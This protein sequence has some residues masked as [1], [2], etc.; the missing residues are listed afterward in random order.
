MVLL[1][2]QMFDCS[3][4][5]SGQQLTSNDSFLQ[6]GAADALKH[7]AVAVL[8]VDNNLPLMI[9]F[10]EWCCR[11]L[12]QWCCRRPQCL[13]VAVLIV[14]NN[15]PL[16]TVQNFYRMVVPRLKRLTVAVLIVDKHLSSVFKQNGAADALK[17]FSS[18]SGMTVFYRRP[19]LTVEPSNNSSSNDWTTTPQVFTEWCLPSNVGCSS[20]NS[21][22]QLTSND[23]FYRMVCCS[24]SGQQL[25]FDSFYRMVLLDNNSDL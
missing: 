11:R 17:V 8:I 16:M 14:D 18:N 23:S 25:T 24:S 15:L 20:S 2:P 21:G 9:D 19:S 3:S 5:N 12:K 22:Q 10:T 7:L 13:A 6:N 4:S 1:T